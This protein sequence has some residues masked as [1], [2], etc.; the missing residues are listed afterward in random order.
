MKRLFI[1]LLSLFLLTPFSAHASTTVTLTAP[2]HRHLDGTFFDDALATD[3]LPDGKYG[4]LIFHKSTFVS[5]WKIDPAFIEDVNAMTINY[6]VSGLGEGKGKEAATAFMNRLKTVTSIGRVEALPYS[7][8]SEY[9]VNKFMPHDRGYILDVSASRLT[10]LL[11]RFTYA[12]T[13]YASKKYF[14]LTSPQIRL[15]NL[16]SARIQSSASYL[17]SQLLE[18][19]KLSQ[20]KLLSVSITQTQRQTLAYDLAAQ[21]NT[22]RDSIRISRGKFTITSANQKLPITLTNDFPKPTVVNLSI[23]S[24]NQRIFVDDIKL[25]TIPAKSKMQVLIPVKAYTSG[26]SGFTVTL[27]TKDGSVFGQTTTYPLTVAFISPVATWITTI[28]AVVLFGAAILKSL[29]R[30]RKGKR[31]HEHR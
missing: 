7:N 15:I 20:V 27:R 24:I 17:D 31:S 26:D 23:N 19:Y 28:A 3:L 14:S 13:Q 1:L 10:S 18:N 30:F 21:L 25:I 22:L 6:Q 2:S 11:G 4:S 9:W 16:S 8:P 29:R 12:P 5:N